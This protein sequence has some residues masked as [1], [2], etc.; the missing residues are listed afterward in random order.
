MALVNEYSCTEHKYSPFSL[1]CVA[2]IISA[3]GWPPRKAGPSSSS[4][5]INH[6]VTSN[7]ASISLSDSITSL[8]IKS[9]ELVSM[10][11]PLTLVMTRS[12]RTGLVVTGL[13]NCSVELV[14]L[15]QNFTKCLR[16]K[17]APF[18][19]DIKKT[20]SPCTIFST[21]SFFEYFVSDLPKR[22]CR[23]SYW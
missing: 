19:T 8:S 20:L 7:S 10:A 12:S 23:Y 9:L 11:S 13:F 3:S 4:L 21:F 18:Y 1:A 6:C 22:S 5:N 17:H 2:K 14:L 16:V 15:D